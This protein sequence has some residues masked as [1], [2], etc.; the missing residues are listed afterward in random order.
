MLVLLEGCI[1]LP[2][3]C[4]WRLA[5][6]CRRNVYKIFQ[7]L[8][9]K[10]ERFNNHFQQLPTIYILKNEI[11]TYYKLSALLVCWSVGSCCALKNFPYTVFL[12][13]RGVRGDLFGKFYLVAFATHRLKCWYSITFLLSRLKRW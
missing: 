12:F 1:I 7:R 3:T 11:Y 9:T 13:H 2:T 10:N 4:V 5:V 8:P 6:M